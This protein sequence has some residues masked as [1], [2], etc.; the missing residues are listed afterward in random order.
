MKRKNILYVGWVGFGNLGD[1]A[2]RD[3]FIKKLTPLLRE[4][5][6]E[7]KIKTVRPG[8][9]F[10]QEDLLGFRP[11]LVVLGGGSVLKS[12]YVNLLFIAEKKGIP[13]VIWGSGIDWISLKELSRIK[14]NTL[15]KSSPLI[16]QT[17]DHCQAVGVRGPHTFKILQ[18][19]GCDPK[20]MLISGD[21]GF[22][23]QPRLRKEYL[24]PPLS[25]Q[26]NWFGSQQRIIGV[27]WGTS[28]N[29][30]YGHNENKTGSQLAA[31]LN[32]LSRDFSLF[33]F[34]VWSK[35]LPAMERLAEALQ[36]KEIFISRKV[37]TAPTL[38]HFLKRCDLTI[39]F[40]LHANIFSA[41]VGTPFISL[42]YR[43]KC[44]DFAASVQLEEMVFRFD[45]PY[46]TELLLNKVITLQNKRADYQRILA[47]HN[48]GYRKL[49]TSILKRSVSLLK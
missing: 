13:T 31:A 23:L 27:N 28:M 25:K 26:I 7:P 21:P 20:K 49:L 39:N 42:G 5:G 6:I 4:F 15:K 45:H 46:L 40:K 22:L 12:P 35:D 2:C 29:R 19:M 11:D 37:Y 30:V 8:K 43:S 1:D 32:K 33:F 3:L 36:N 41:A 18:A 16:Q 24:T 38:A 44:F 9:H 10:T 34:P 14:E 48:N 47:G 17:V